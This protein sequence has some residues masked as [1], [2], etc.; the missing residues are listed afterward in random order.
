[1]QA[2]R[3]MRMPIY[4]VFTLK[5]RKEGRRWVALCEE[6]GT[7]TYAF[8][9]REAEKRISE[10]VSCHLNTLEEVGERARFFS[11]NNIRMVHV[12]PTEVSTKF[13][14]SKD[15]DTFAMPYIY[16]MAEALLRP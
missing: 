1:M 13:Y 5:F 12:K 4:I 10:A 8:T 7:S 14:C 16:P 2:E 11:E 3:R 15:K 6:L 9:L